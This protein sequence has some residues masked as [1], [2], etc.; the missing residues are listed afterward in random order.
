[1]HALG[2]LAGAVLQRACGID[3][4]IHPVQ[5][6]APILGPLGF[7]DVQADVFCGSIPSTRNGY[8][9][10]PVGSETCHER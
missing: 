9:F 6:G 1:M 8:A 4:R 2:R 5:C 7:G 3:D 10:M